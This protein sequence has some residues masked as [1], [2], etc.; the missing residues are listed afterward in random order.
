MD[1]IQP[2]LFMV[3]KV[4]IALAQ[5]LIPLQGQ[6]TGLSVKFHPECLFNIHSGHDVK[7]SDEIWVTT[8]N[9]HT[10]K[11]FNENGDLSASLK[12]KL[13]LT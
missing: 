1:L 11:D 4:D 8:N 3:Q 9:L 6:K 2:K 13:L 10:I 12:M 7:F 5:V